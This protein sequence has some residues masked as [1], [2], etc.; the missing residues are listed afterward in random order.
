MFHWIKAL[1]RAGF[2]SRGVTLV[3]AYMVLLVAS[4]GLICIAEPSDSALN[5]PGQALWWSI[6]TSTTVGYGDMYP[7]SS[8][9]KVIAAVLPMFMGIGLGAAFITH[10]ASVLIERKDKNMHGETSYQ[11]S[12]HILIVG[13]IPRKLNILWNRSGQTKHT[14]IRISWSWPMSP[15]IPSWNSPTPFLSKGGLIPFMP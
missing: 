5:H 11:G 7:T 4:T 10:V 1:L 15:G 13:H 14:R 2:Q 12:D 3:F 6:V 8:W 9:G